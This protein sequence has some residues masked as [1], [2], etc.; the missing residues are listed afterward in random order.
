[1]SQKKIYFN[2][3]AGFTLQMKME[4]GGNDY[5]IVRDNVRGNGSYTFNLSEN[6]RNIVRKADTLAIIL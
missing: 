6:E 2:N 3:P 5:L 1:M 4:A